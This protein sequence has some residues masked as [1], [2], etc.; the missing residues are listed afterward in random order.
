MEAKT[1][2]TTEETKAQLLELAK[3]DSENIKSMRKNI[4][5]MAWI[6]IISFIISALSFAIFFG[7]TGYFR[8]Y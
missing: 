8:A 7:K 1:N 2:L 4:Q 5:F 3:Q 6:L